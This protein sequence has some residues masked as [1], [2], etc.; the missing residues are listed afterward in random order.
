LFFPSIITGPLPFLSRPFL[1]NFTGSSFASRSDNASA[2][3]LYPVE[4]LCKCSII[5]SRH[6]DKRKKNLHPAH[7][8]IFSFL[9]SSRT[10]ITPPSRTLITPPSC[11]RVVA[12]RHHLV[13]GKQLTPPSRHCTMPSFRFSSRPGCH[14]FPVPPP[15]PHETLAQVLPRSA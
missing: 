9:S 4:F 7:Q 1:S 13:T 10:L 12:P 3:N 2:R 11:H 14:R 8:L 15:M 5:A 6:Y